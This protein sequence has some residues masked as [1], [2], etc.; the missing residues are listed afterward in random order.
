MTGPSSRAETDDT[1]GLVRHHRTET[2][3]LSCFGSPP[4]V[5]RAHGE[6]TAR[7][8]PPN[9]PRII[10]PTEDSTYARHRF[11]LKAWNIASAVCS[12]G[13]GFWRNP[14]FPSG[15]WISCTPLSGHPAIKTTLT[16]ASCSRSLCSSSVPLI[17][18]ITMSVNTSATEPYRVSRRLSYVSTATKAGVC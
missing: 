17:P 4:S 12:S 16:S 9:H 6:K 18:G 10:P 1:S 11:P 14:A 5:Q 8:Y 7:I 13:R 15:S 3:M 2:G